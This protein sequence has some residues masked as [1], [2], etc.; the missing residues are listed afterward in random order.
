MSTTWTPIG[1]LTENPGAWSDN[2]GGF[3][4]VARNDDGVIR[5]QF[6]PHPYQ[7]EPYTLYTGDPKDQGG[8]NVPD[9]AVAFRSPE[10]AAAHR[11]KLE[12]QE[13]LK[14][15]T[16]TASGTVRT[17]AASVDAAIQAAAEH[18]RYR[19]DGGSASVRVD[20][21][22]AADIECSYA[23]GWAF[24]VERHSQWAKKRA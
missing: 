24:R 9:G 19:L 15:V 4:F 20:G 14:G 7:G 22:L 11:R 1:G 2:N 21:V 23:T 18:L 5:R 13:A 10:K 3:I 16:W 8:P 17:K 6:R 12:E